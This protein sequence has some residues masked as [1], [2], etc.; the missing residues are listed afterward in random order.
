MSILSQWIWEKKGKKE[1]DKLI[2]TIYF[3]SPSISNMLSFQDINI[4]KLLI[5]NEIFHI[6]F[7]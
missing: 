2:V 1:T 6:L 3:I 5:I 7:S 4:I